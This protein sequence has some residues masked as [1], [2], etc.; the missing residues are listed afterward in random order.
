MQLQFPERLNCLLMLFTAGCVRSPARSLNRSS[1]CPPPPTRPESPLSLTWAVAPLAA[2]AFFAPAA[3]S[4]N[5]CERNNA[6]T[7]GGI[8]CSLSNR[9]ITQL[10]AGDFDNLSNLQHLRLNGNDLTSLPS[11]IF[12]NLSNLQH[13]DLDRNDLTS[14]PSGIFD[15]LSN[16]QHLDLYGN[17]LTSLPSG[18]FDNLSNLQHLW[19]DGNDLTSLP[20]GI[21]DNLSNLQDLWLNGNDL[22]SL[23][24]GIFDNLSN[25]QHL[26]LYGNDLTSLPSGI[27]DNLSNL[28][29]LWLYGNDLTSL[30]SGI[31]DNL[32]NL[33]HLYL[34]GN[35]LTSL[36]SGIFDNLSNLQR[37]NLDGNDLTSLPSGIFDNLSNLQDLWLDGNDLTSLPSGIF[38]NLSN[39]QDLW[40]YGNDLTSLPSGI[41]DNLSNL[42]DL[43]LYGNDLTS[44]PSGIFDNLSNLQDLWLDGNDLTS[45]PS[46]IFDNLSNLQILRLI[47]NSLT[48]L[49]ALPSGT[50]PSVDVKLPTCD[51][52]NTD[53]G[54]SLSTSSGTLT[55]GGAD[56]TYT[57]TL[58]T[59]PTADV[60]VT[61][62]SDDTGAVTASPATLTFTAD[63]YNT[64]Q[65]VTV[66]PQDDNDGENETA[67]TVS[68][69]PS[70]GGYGSSQKAD[71]TAAVNDDDSKGLTLSTSS[72][73]LTEGGA[74]V[75]YTVTLDTQPTA[76]VTV[77][78]ASDDTGAVTASPATLTFTADNYNT[79]QTVTVSPQDDNDGENE[80]AVTVS[81][82]PSGG[83]YGSSQKAD[84]TAAVNDDDSKGLT[85]STSSGTLTEGGA[86]VTY[87]VTLDTQPTADVTVTIASDDT[88]AVTASP[89]TLTFTADNYNTAQTVT[90]S[91]QDDN[92]G[93]NETAVTVSHTPS[94]GGYGSSQKADY[95]AAV[96]DDDSKGLTLS[97]SSGTLT[98][99][100]SAVTYTVTLDSQPTADV[101]VS[102]SS[103]DSGAVTASPA[104]LT[105]N[106]T[107]YTTAQTVTLSAQQDADGENE[108]VTISH[109]PSGDGYDNSLKA[110]Y[111]A[112]V[113]DDDNDGINLVFSKTEL[114]ISEY[115][116]VE[117]Y[118]L[119]L[120]DEPTENVTI[121]LTSSFVGAEAPATLDRSSVT[122][123]TTNWSTPQ[124]IT[125]TGANDTV[126]NKE[127]RTMSIIHTISGSQTSLGSV[128]VIVKDNEG[129]RLRLSSYSG[130]LKGKGS[131]LTYDV[132][133]YKRPT[134]SVT[135]AVASSDTRAVTVSPATLTFNS[136]NYDT[137]WTVTLTAK[138]D[139]DKTVT[140]SNNPSGGGYAPA[141]AEDFTAQLSDSG[142]EVPG[143]II[144]PTSLKI[145]ENSRDPVFYTV[146]LNKKPE[147]NVIITPYSDNEELVKVFSMVDLAT[148]TPT[149]L[150]FT[151]A[152]WDTPQKLYLLGVNDD[153]KNNSSRKTSISHSVWRGDDKYD[154]GSVSV[155]VLDD[156]IA[157]IEIS[158][159]KLVTIKKDQETTYTVRLTSQPTSNVEVKLTT[160]DTKYIKFTPDKLTF[161]PSNYSRPQIVRVTGENPTGYNIA[162]GTSERRANVSSI[163]HTISEDSEYNK[164]TKYANFV[165]VEEE[166]ET[167]LPEVTITPKNLDII[168]EPSSYN[169]SL[170][171]PPG[172]TVGVEIRFAHDYLMIAGKGIFPIPIVNEK[173]DGKLA[174]AI[175]YFDNNNYNKPRTIRVHGIRETS[176]TTISHTLFTTELVKQDKG[177]NRRLYRKIS[178]LDSVTVAV[179]EPEDVAGESTIDRLGEIAEKLDLR[180]VALEV[181]E[182]SRDSFDHSNNYALANSINRYI[183]D[184]YPELEEFRKSTE[185]SYD[186]P[187]EFRDLITNSIDS[188]A[189]HNSID[190]ELEQCVLDV[191]IEL[192][193][194]LS[195][196]AIAS[197]VMQGDLGGALEELI[198]YPLKSS[199]LVLKVGTIGAKGLYKYA[200]NLF[201]VTTFNSPTDA[202]N[203]I[204]DF[205]VS[206]GPALESG[207][208][209]LQQ[210]FSQQTL[211]LPLSFGEKAGNRDLD[212][213][214]DSSAHTIKAGIRGSF[215][216]SR[217][218]DDKGG[219]VTDGN[220][221]SYIL[222]F[223][224]TPKP[225]LD[226][227]LN[228][229]YDTS[230]VKYESTK[231]I[232]KTEGTYNTW[233]TGVHPFIK[234]KASDTLDLYATVG[235]GRINTELN[236]DDVADSL[237]SFVEGQ[238]RESEGIYSSF[239]AG[240]SYTV[241]QSDLTNLA[242]S[243]DGTTTTVFDT[244]SQNARFTTA[245]SHDFVFEPG[246]LNTGLDLALLMSDAS[247]SV[248]ELTGRLGWL[249]Q[250]S[251]FSGSGRVR[252]LLFGGQRKEWGFGGSLN[253]GFTDN[254]EGLNLEVRPSIGR[255]GRR[256]GLDDEDWFIT[257]GAD[258]SFSNATYAPQLGIG[259]GYG[260]RV[261]NGVLTPYTDAFLSEA[262]SSYSGGLRYDFDQDDLE[263]ELETTH[264]R[265][266]S[267]S[268]DN[269]IDLRL[270]SAF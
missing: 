103:S 216:Y 45:L 76:D 127:D 31:F 195:G 205:L 83:G 163:K 71:Y 215:D 166:P 221:F 162:P 89:A 257:D 48:C 191:G 181:C 248:M 41:F 268:S 143:V 252:V 82:T 44:L 84:Y 92:D 269:R 29:D 118:T 217:F 1:D 153:V 178:N 65:T 22:T 188:F 209:D 206:H 200:S 39:L 149:K 208:F 49:P 125:V 157:G 32:S 107:N 174:R 258:L 128:E 228:L 42:Q 148:L 68:H 173:Q 219:F 134:G 247:P 108:V 9:G 137:K 142:D 58:D 242:L 5:I 222:G 171:K 211:V 6:L 96:N 86:D 119:R 111:T 12:D 253:Y 115:G 255:T 87:T 21:F 239:T 95:T 121:D 114:T 246:V 245:L 64:A 120:K 243:L 17:D 123:T 27:F 94:G 156:D 7:N 199:R 91:P 229:I 23:P 204:T 13:L 16:L 202:A 196:L 130:A 175:I 133:L 198:L 75:T 104:T 101:T 249:P 74:D 158:Q 189:S 93:E 105:F 8:T 231:S 218:S 110:D 150:T 210:A 244:H 220:S 170:V 81:H 225:S 124:T 109:I 136:S 233:L 236:I 35:D 66:S 3:H 46:G 197:E 70:G 203:Y 102:I 187:Q 224:I 97:T 145:S 230:T 122:F 132:S 265:R 161:T 172:R 192:A 165:V 147:G 24:S 155:E 20:S 67:V 261:G 2:L 37:L 47:G 266:S 270:R 106:T 62:A 131:K 213:Q 238:S 251:R 207:N 69:T 73:T 262:S 237:L 57:V 33:Q 100:G 141:N 38:D 232:V 4:Q 36:P 51:G 77:T 14:L 43:Y 234:W 53:K 99:G 152:D 190:L 52:S 19:L 226:T 11:G 164:A 139:V 154:V 72:G 259:L 26:Y 227:S 146:V 78:I 63:N 201:K 85:L 30:P 59:Q 140:I 151:P 180:P 50:S 138:Q 54:L 214:N 116:G 182:E 223:D 235:Y 167:E 80:T 25:L 18:I 55:E 186:F 40:L 28:Q 212:Q 90:V 264:N 254:G 61:I 183:A 10:S 135:V 113:S 194:T 79:A 144:S 34:Y 240:I 15:N 129:Y 168:D 88:G 56:V 159:E 117:M 185:G 184:Q 241:W 60:T 98:E 260:F 267:G 176:K 193:T 112:T 160:I 250:D 177:V 179:K 169:V 263:L 256:F 126:V